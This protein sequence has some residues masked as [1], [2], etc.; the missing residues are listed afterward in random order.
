MISGILLAFSIGALALLFWQ[1][2]G[3]ERLCVALI[4]AGI[5]L[6]PVVD[7]VQ[8]GNVRWV[9]ALLDASLLA[10][11]TIIS[12]RNDRYWLIPLAGYQGIVVITHIVPLLRADFLVW[13]AITVRLMVWV[14]MMGTLVFGAYEARAI[15]VFRARQEA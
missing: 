10:A 9:L 14:A 1:G 2:Q 4:V 8:A 3:P 5:L 13:T 7:P 12:L 6:T 11:F 15:R